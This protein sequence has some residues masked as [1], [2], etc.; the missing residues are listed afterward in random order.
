MLCFAQ[1]V[2]FKA[3]AS[4]LLIQQLGK[5]LKHMPNMSKCISMCTRRK[6]RGYTFLWFY[7]THRQAEG[8]QSA[9]SDMIFYLLERIKYHVGEYSQECCISMQKATR[10][11]FISVI[12]VSRDKVREKPSDIMKHSNVIILKINPGIT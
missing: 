11:C 9:A 5:R 1:W 3:E 4:S 7:W 2:T 10:L 6:S 12:V 8:V